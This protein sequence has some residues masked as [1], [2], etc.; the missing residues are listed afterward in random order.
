MAVVTRM[1][2]FVPWPVQAPSAM[3]LFR[4]KRDFG[5]T[6]AI[7]TA[8]AISDTVATAAAISLTSVVQT[9]AAVNNLSA[10]VAEVLDC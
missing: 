10:G 3:T 2:C 7:V 8:I 4:P 9:A 5:F 6:A 1:S